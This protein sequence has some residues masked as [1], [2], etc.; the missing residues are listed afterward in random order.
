MNTGFRIESKPS[1]ILIDAR[2]EKVFGASGSTLSMSP[3]AA[4]MF[5][6]TR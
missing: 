6:V 1:Q 3:V 2:F 4:Y 5:V